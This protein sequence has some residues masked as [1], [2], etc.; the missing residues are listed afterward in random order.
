MELKFNKNLPEFD[1]C[2][3]LAAYG[4]NLNIVVTVSL[5]FIYWKSMKNYLQYLY[6]DVIIS[7]VD[8]L[9]FL[10]KSV[11]ITNLLALNKL[12]WKR[13]LTNGKKIKKK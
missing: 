12:I 6:E 1:V 5:Y 7:Y 8:K 2:F 13:G 9:F 11:E 3:N 4:V 10:Y